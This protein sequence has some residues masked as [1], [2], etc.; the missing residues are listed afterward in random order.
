MK[1]KKESMQIN[2][3]AEEI[4]DLGGIKFIKLHTPSGDIQVTVD[5]KEV[6]KKI[7]EK[8][9]TI[10]RQSAISFSGELKENK[11]APGG[12]L[13]RGGAGLGR[14][15]LRDYERHQVLQEVL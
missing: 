7:F 10:T 3:W 13:L 8:V 2:G 6:S 4:R 1:I 5:K 11:D 9:D 12:Q 14:D 15:E